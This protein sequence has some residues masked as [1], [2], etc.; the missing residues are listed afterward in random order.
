MDIVFSR[1]DRDGNGVIDPLEVRPASSPTTQIEGAA[2]RK[3]TVV[4]GRH[5]TKTMREGGAPIR[6][7]LLTTPFLLQC[8]CFFPGLCLQVAMLSCTIMCCHCCVGVAFSCFAC[9]MWHHDCGISHL[10]FLRQ[11][12]G[13]GTATS[14]R[15]FPR[16]QTAGVVCTVVWHAGIRDIAGG[17]TSSQE[18]S[19]LTRCSPSN[20]W[21]D[22]HFSRATIPYNATGT[23]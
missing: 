18:K 17:S 1:Y 23:R 11:S 9:R 3:C 4:D 10:R 20:Y 13:V 15:Y 7:L 2:R 22:R 5:H 14:Y 16:W 19:L 6:V 12:V 8:A 21:Q